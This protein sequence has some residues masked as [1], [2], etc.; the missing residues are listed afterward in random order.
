MRGMVG[1][2]GREVEERVL[3]S[4]VPGG[5]RGLNVKDLFLGSNVD[6]IPGEKLKFEYLDFVPK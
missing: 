4:S 2:G 6:G 5:V 3:V 1:D